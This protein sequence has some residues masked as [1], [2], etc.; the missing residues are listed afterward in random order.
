M[1]PRKVLK[2]LTVLGRGRFWMTSILA[3]STSK[4][5]PEMICPSTT[6]SR[7]MKWDFS[8]LTTSRFLTHT[9]SIFVRWARQLSKS[10]PKTEKS[11][12]KTSKL[13]PRKSEKNCRHASLEGHGGI[14][15]SEWNAFEGES[16][17]QTSERSLLLIIGVDSNLIVARVSVQKAEVIWSCQ[18]VQDL[19]DE[20]KREVVLLGRG[21]QLLIVD[22]DPP[23]RW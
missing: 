18:S 2:S 9:S 15:K 4:P 7:T 19:V 6:P 1:C 5:L 21:V 17:K 11:S 3:L 23:L 14:T 22:A 12:M 10:F 20:R 16:A 13:S 8:Q